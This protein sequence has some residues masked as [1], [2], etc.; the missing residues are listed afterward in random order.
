MLSVSFLG[1]VTALVTSH[2]FEKQIIKKIELETNQLMVDYNQDG[3]EELWNDVRERVHLNQPNRLLYSI[4]L[5]DGERDFD[6]IDVLDLKSGWQDLS[7]PVELKVLITSLKNGHKLIVASRL[8]DMRALEKVIASNFM[9]VLGLIILLGI[10]GGIILSG[11]YVKRIT[12]IQ[13]VT[14][15][16]GEGNFDSRIPL[17][18]SDDVFDE[19]AKIFNSMLNRIEILIDEIQRVSSNIAHEMRTPLGHVRQKMEDVLQNTT[20][21]EKDERTIE[22]AIEEIDQTLLMFSAIMRLSEIKSGTRKAR[23]ENY[24]LS[25]L[26]EDI[27]AIYEPIVVDKNKKLTWNIQENI[28]VSG[29]KSLMKQL[30]VN[31]IENFLQH[32]TEDTSMNI[33]LY[34]KG[35]ECFLITRDTGHGIEDIEYSLKAFNSGVKSKGTGIGLSLVDAIARLHNYNVE[36]SNNPGFQVQIKMKL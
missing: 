8:S 13:N 26:V 32:T 4:V 36:Y 25:H 12:E 17:K 30:L 9:F 23:F 28:F 18:G 5:A 19:I 24:N 3:L 22:S 6:R 35:Q 16:I 33:S 11:R 34:K 29:E 27:C 20:L 15:K 14:Q 1:L 2:H 10:F 7:D 31:L 21:N